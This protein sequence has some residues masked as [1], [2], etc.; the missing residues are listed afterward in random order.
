MCSLPLCQVHVNLLNLLLYSSTHMY[1]FHHVRGMTARK[2]PNVAPKLIPSIPRHAATK[3]EC[4]KS[5]LKNKTLTS[6]RCCRHRMPPPSPAEEEAT[7]PFW[8]SPMTGIRWLWLKR[9]LPPPPLAGRREKCGGECSRRK[10]D[11]AR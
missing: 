9:R 4:R 7:V 5:L 6:L 2:W 10:T 1:V 3:L 11:A 8:S